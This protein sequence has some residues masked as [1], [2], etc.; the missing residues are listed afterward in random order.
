MATDIENIKRNIAVLQE[1]I[2]NCAIKSGKEPKDIKMVIVTKKVE[3]NKIKQLI[4][5]GF[6]V[7]AENKVQEF[8]EKYDNISSIHKCEW[9]FIGHLQTNK[10]KYIVDKASMIHSLD[11]IELARE[12]EKRAGKLG[13]VVD[14]LVQVNISKEESKFGISKE[15]LKK[16]LHELS[17][18]KNIRVKGLMTMAPLAENPTDIAWVFQELNKIAIDIKGENINNIH[19][20]FLSMGMSNDFE[21]AIENGANI[22]RLGSAIFN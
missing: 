18:F 17:S 6:S 19:M 10:V 22:I 13:I 15:E 2:N 4:E 7:F 21:L 11:R 8:V 5:E 3:T 9:H 20:D 14:A 12:I 1:K 16:F